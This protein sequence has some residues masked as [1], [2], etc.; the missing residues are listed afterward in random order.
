MPQ[1]SGAPTAM[2]VSTHDAGALYSP[3][4]WSRDTRDGERASRLW[5]YSG[6]E[7]RRGGRL[8]NPRFPRRAVALRSGRPVLFAA[9]G[10]HGLWTLPG[11]RGSQYGCL[12][13]AIQS[14]SKLFREIMIN[15][16][17]NYMLRIRETARELQQSLYIFPPS[18]MTIWA[19]SSRWGNK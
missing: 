9:R 15:C 14:Q 7:L 12:S 10:S 11:N 6:H 2:Y 4:Q 18:W 17:K 5:T 13:F 19:W 8:Q 1:G 16:K 3:P